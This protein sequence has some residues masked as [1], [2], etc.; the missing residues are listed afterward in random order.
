MLSSEEQPGK[1]RAEFCPL[2]GCC[3]CQF[4]PSPSG[5]LCGGGQQE[6]PQPQTPPA[7]QAEG[8]R[9]SHTAPAPSPGALQEAEARL[10]GNRNTLS[11]ICV[12]QNTVQR[13]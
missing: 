9:C 10:R 12:S 13:E 7:I 8:P 1:S 4:P 5:L 3:L 6:E 11:F 2:A